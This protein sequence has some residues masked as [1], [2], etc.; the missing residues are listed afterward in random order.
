[1]RFQKNG[2]RG[3]GLYPPL[4][5]GRASSSARDEEKVSA[6]TFI[7]FIQTISSSMFYD[8]P[9]IQSLVYTNGTQNR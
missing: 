6:F 4:R 9:W 5:Y 3:T 7:L 2:L 1:M 8:S